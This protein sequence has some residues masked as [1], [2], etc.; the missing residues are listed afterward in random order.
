MA[1]TGSVRCQIIG[2][3]TKLNGADAMFIAYVPMTGDASA[4]TATATATLYG[5]QTS[6]YWRLLFA[7]FVLGNDAD[8]E[9]YLKVETEVFAN[10]SEIEFWEKV[11]CQGVGGNAALSIGKI[12]SSPIFNVWFP[13]VIE[14]SRGVNFKGVWNDNVNTKTYNFVVAGELLIPSRKYPTRAL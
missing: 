5:M 3:E 8:Y 9:A 4:G 10:T 6:A 2:Y 7:S 12:Q 13:L 11:D 1:V 14:S